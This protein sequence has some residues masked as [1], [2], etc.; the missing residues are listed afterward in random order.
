MKYIGPDYSAVNGIILPGTDKAAFPRTMTDS[1]IAEF[2]AYYPQLLPYFTEGSNNGDTGGGGNGGN[3]GTG[4]YVP[5]AWWDV[6]PTNLA[7]LLDAA[8]AQIGTI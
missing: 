3:N 5:L 2:L 7:A 8:T 4:Q 6:T 1:Q